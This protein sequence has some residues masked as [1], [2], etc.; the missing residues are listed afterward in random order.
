METHGCE[1]VFYGSQSAQK[2]THIDEISSAPWQLPCFSILL[3]FQS[4]DLT[5]TMSVQK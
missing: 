1:T 2:D 5:G 4:F 3:L